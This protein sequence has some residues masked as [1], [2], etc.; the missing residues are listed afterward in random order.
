VRREHLIKHHMVRVRLG[1]QID[2]TIPSSATYG[3]PTAPIEYREPLPADGDRTPA[4]K[5]PFNYRG[6]H[7]ANSNAP[8]NLPFESSVEL[9]AQ[10]ILETDHN[11]VELKTQ[12]PTYR[13]IG[14]DGESHRHTFDIYARLRDG[15][16][17]GIAAKPAALLIETD[18]VGTLLR[19]KDQGLKGILDDVSFVTE[20]FASDEA[21]WNAR[22][23][24]LSRRLRN[25][26]EYLIAL[27]VLKGVRGAVPFRA[28]FAGAEVPAHRRT[29]L[30]C[31]IDD[32]LLRPVAPGRIE[33]TTLMIV[34]L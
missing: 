21:A 1:D 25:E 20:K 33:D 3:K 24:L 8:R 6:C 32:R 30:W 15:R 18:L 22:E 7:V 13:Y 9:K 12:Q 2:Y 4:E 26:E 28:L 16:R 23:I 31:L 17:I 34:T 27:N 19:I 10:L 5:S 29:A 11:V 14:A